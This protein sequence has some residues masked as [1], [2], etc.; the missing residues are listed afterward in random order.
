MKLRFRDSI[1]RYIATQSTQ[2]KK[3]K[4]HFRD[5]VPFDVR[6][7]DVYYPRNNPEE[8]TRHTYLKGA[9]MDRLFESKK[10]LI[11]AETGFGTGLNFL[12]TWKMFEESNVSES[13]DFVSVEGFP[14]WDV[15]ELKRCHD[16]FPSHAK[17]S[18]ELRRKWPTVPGIHRI[19]LANGRVRLILLIGDVRTML[20]QMNFKADA[21]LLDGFNP[22]T[23]KDM[24]SVDVMKETAR[25]S[26]SD[27]TLATYTVSRSIRDRLGEAGW[28]NIQ[29]R[30]GF[31]RKR[32]CLAAHGVERKESS[33]SGNAPW[34]ALPKKTF[35]TTSRIAVIGNGTKT[36]TLLDISLSQITREISIQVSRHGP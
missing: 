35:D 26:R 3:R 29:K 16:T 28:Q 10:R 19:R 12:E 15:N 4:L 30:K 9:Q 14:I 17:N 1:I 24:W 13:L 25:L 6:F 18:E 33:T 8:D 31:G 20:P 22:K 2:S 36:F 7:D 32:E 21:W 23:N 11:V 5:G 27:A 34:F